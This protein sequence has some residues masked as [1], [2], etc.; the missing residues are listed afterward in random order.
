MKEARF[1]AIENNLIKCKLCPH[2]CKILKGNTGLCIARRNTGEVLQAESYGQL[3]S[4]AIDPIEKKPLYRFYPGAKILSV[5]SYGCNM[6]CKFCQNHE[7]SQTRPPAKYY[8]PRE[9]LALAKSVPD[10]LGVAFTYNEPLVGFEYLV[11]CAKLLKSENLKV[12]VVTNGLMNPEPFGELLELVDAF[13]IDVKSFAPQFYKQHGGDLETVRRNVETAAKP[14][15]LEVTTLII[16]GQ[17][18]QEEE[19]VALS[20]WLSSVSPK[21]PLH[22][23]RFFPRYKWTQT[24]STPIDTIYQLANAARRRLKYVYEGNI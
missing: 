19:I 10:N 2:H 11:D 9:L 15:H 4:V 13:N 1:Y 20:D 14:A 8:S 18:D 21:I 6:R 16:P 12:V 5:G 24:P 17:N 7:I 23:S 3:S 22:L